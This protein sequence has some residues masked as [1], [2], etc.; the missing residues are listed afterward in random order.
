MNSVW[1]FEEVTLDDAF[2]EEGRAKLN[3]YNELQRNINSYK[4][5]LA[6]LFQ[7]NACTILK[8]D[9]QAISDEALAENADAVR[10]LFADHGADISDVELSGIATA[11][12]LVSEPRNDSVV[13][14]FIRSY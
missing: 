12:T 2:I 7:D 8:D 6:N 14:T 9:I 11:L 10:K 13:G 1:G 4:A 5:A 3:A